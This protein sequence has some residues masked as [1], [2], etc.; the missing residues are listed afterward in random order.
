MVDGLSP[1]YEQRARSLLRAF[2]RRYRAERMDELLSTLADLEEPARDRPSVRASVDL[3]IAGWGER[4]RGHPPLLVWLRYWFTEKLPR[5]YHGWLIDDLAGWYL[6]RRVLR[7]Y[8]V[9][10]IGVLC[11]MVA[12]AVAGGP[13]LAWGFPAAMIAPGAISASIGVWI[14]S[15][16]NVA[17]HRARVLRRNGYDE[18]GRPAVWD[19]FRYRTDGFIHPPYRA[20]PILI[21]LA[22]A[23]LITLPFNYRAL[24]P[25]GLVASFVDANG[26]RP[27]RN[28]SVAVV[29]FAIML[30]ASSAYAVRV[31][32]KI[33]EAITK[34]SA[35][36]S[37]RPSGPIAACISSAVIGVGVADAFVKL[38]LALAAL[39]FTAAAAVPALAVTGWYALKLERR[40]NVVVPMP[41]IREHR[42]RAP[43]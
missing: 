32:R 24:F 31:W 39:S 16:Q 18:R 23:L 12:I 5:E 27:G 11:L 42:T 3:V 36:T 1:R 29:W 17:K 14:G 30:V 19:G 35:T 26:G 21:S 6:L 9:V 22:A 2:P 10:A 20:T 33:G 37:V 25:D 34:E 38:P 8:A 43:S 15:L 4:W 13:F 7:V 28:G 40:H 41:R